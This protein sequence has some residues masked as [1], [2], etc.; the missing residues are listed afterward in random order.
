MS[1][2][3]KKQSKIITK[4]KDTFGT[5]KEYWSVPPKGKLIPY[6]EVAALSGADFGVL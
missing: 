6:K 4:V 5:V 2:E 3:A 1:S